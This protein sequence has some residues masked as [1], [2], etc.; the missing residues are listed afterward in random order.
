MVMMMKELNFDEDIEFEFE[1][2]PEEYL[3]GIDLES[4]VQEI[5]YAADRR[6]NG[7]VR[8]RR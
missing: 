1:D 6:P 8:S 7:D 4:T 5:D 3:E 2:V